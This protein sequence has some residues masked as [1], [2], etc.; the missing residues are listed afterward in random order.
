M[1]IKDTIGGF[2]IQDKDNLTINVDNIDIPTIKKPTET[3]L[4]ALYFAWKIVKHVKSNAIVI[5]N[6]DTLIGVGAGQMSRIDSTKIAINKARLPLNGA[7]LASDAFFPFRDC[8]DE[9]A[10]HGITAIIQP[11]GSIRD[12]EV[13]DAANEHNIAMVLTHIRHFKH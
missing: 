4:Q 10:K 12:K 5:T 6:N 13:I 1:E 11:G 8:V 2:L 3:E 7:V 9:A